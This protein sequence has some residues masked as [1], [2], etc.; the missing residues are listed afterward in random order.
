MCPRRL[1]L[2]AA[3]FDR[4]PGDR[5]RRALRRRRP[6]RQPR[7]ARCGRGAG[8]ARAR[9]RRWCSTATSTGST[10]SRRGSPRSSERVARHLRCA[11]TSR[12]RSRARDDIG[13]GCG[14]AY[15]ASVDDDVVSAPTRSSSDLRHAAAP[16]ART[17]RA[18]RA[19][20]ASRRAG[21][22]TARRHRARRRDRR[23]P[24]GASRTTRSTIRRRLPWLDD[25]CRAARVDVFAST[26][27][28][29][30]GAARFRSA[31]AAPD[32][33]QQR[34]R[35]HAELLRH[36]ASGSLSRIATTPSPHAAA[37]RPRARR[38]ARRCDPDRLRH[39]RVSGPLPRALAAGLARA[40]VLLRAHRRGPDYGSRASAHLTLAC[41]A[42][43]AG[44]RTTHALALHHH[45]GARRG[46]R[47]R[48]GARRACALRAARRRGDRRRRRQPRRAP[49]SSRAALADRVIAAPRGRATQMNA[50]AARARGDVLLFLHA[51]TR[52]PDD[53]DHLVARR[54]CALGPR[55]G[56]LRRAHRRARHPL[57][58]VVG[59]D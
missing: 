44:V 54:P 19:A 22:R 31:R 9:P 18:G 32:G 27:T 33:H 4:P 1:P 17:P 3:V 50:G 55:L 42:Q 26:H 7:G 39:A 20:D 43:R 2:S 16:A 40:R 28:C 51:D 23:S 36:A 46:G 59:R 30:A 49:P 8:G 57:L 37:L 25:V 35:R 29:L 47:D 58:A 6:L 24:A 48:R 41:R 10:R 52:L 15:P 13:A 34:R 38:R 53:A 11:A 5:R 56:P 12:P 14:C 21:R 45:A